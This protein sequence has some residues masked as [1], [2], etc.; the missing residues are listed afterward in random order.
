M[1][2]HRNVIANVLQA[3]VFEKKPRE[4]AARAS[5]K[6]Y[7]QEITLGLLPQSH[8]Y[9]LVV[10]NHA[11]PYRGDQVIILPKFDLK[12]YLAAIQNFKIT[13][14]FLVCLVLFAILWHRSLTNDVQVPPIIINMLR[15]K[16]ECAKYDL[17]AVRSLFSGA[18]PLG[19]ETAAEF[20]KLWPNVSIRQGYGKSPFISRPR[21]TVTNNAYLGLTETC[22][23]VSSTH[24]QDIWLGSSG[25]LFPGY[26]ARIV[27]PEGKEITSYDTP[28]ELLVR[29]PS[30][31]LGYLNNDK[32][33]KETFEDGWM[34]TGDEAVFRAG[35]KGT[36]HLFI[37]DR[38]KELIKVKV[39]TISQ[40][41]IRNAEDQA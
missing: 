30:V 16:D 18:A 28:G 2:S 33:N 39:R 20:Q 26:E 5:G 1:I 27:T 40:P 38:I 41:R 24:P 19:M 37:V 36:E 12:S 17:S 25:C 23:V 22:T 3:V 31:V 11:G 34:R 8:I 35:P 13:G 7:G 15:N 10:I 6:K 4:D 32:A 21:V 9:A 14:L 29:S